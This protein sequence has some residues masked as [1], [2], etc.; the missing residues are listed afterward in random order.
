MELHGLEEARKDIRE[1]EDEAERLQRP[2]LLWQVMALRCT[3]AWCDGRLKD[4]ERL[5]AEAAEYGR[6]AHQPLAGQVGAIQEWRL[7]TEQGSLAE[8]RPSVEEFVRA[9]P[10]LRGWRC[11][12]GHVYGELNLRAEAADLLG[13]ISDRNWELLPTDRFRVSA[14]TSAAELCAYVG[15]AR[16][17]KQLY[18]FLGEHE[19]YYVVVPYQAAFL[20]SPAYY[21]GRLAATMRNWSDARRHFEYALKKNRSVKPMLARVLYEYA[22]MLRASGRG[23]G[24]ARRLCRRAL[25]LADR[26]GIVP[27]SRK[28]KAL[29][30]KLDRKVPA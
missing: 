24:E 13:E 7:R 26:L 28:A 2:R 22:A 5:S 23:E 17:A 20:G 15:N 4:A 29:L 19:E 3:L 8:F 11:V 27:L 12:L 25:G 14:L 16:L 21:L 30:R 6:Q 1:F 10:G 9:F 18:A